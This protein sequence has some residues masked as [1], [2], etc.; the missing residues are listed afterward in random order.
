MQ[1]YSFCSSTCLTILVCLVTLKASV[2][3]FWNYAIPPG[4]SRIVINYAIPQACNE[5]SRF[6]INYA[7]PQ[8]CNGLSRFVI[9]YAV[10]Q[11]CNG[12]SRFVI[13]EMDSYDTVL[14]WLWRESFVWLNG[15]KSKFELYPISQSSSY[16]VASFDRK[17]GFSPWLL[18]PPDHSHTALT[19][20]SVKSF[21]S[22]CISY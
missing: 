6:V 5:L 7:I 17:R 20:N 18:F 14:I 22:V 12:L 3:W 15:V 1:L 11:A 16:D 19:V 2:V 13:E 8:A 21:S 10:L 9:D 4:L